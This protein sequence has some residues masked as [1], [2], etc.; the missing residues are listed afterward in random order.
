MKASAARTASVTL[1]TVCMCSAPASRICRLTGAGSPQ[2]VEMIGTRSAKQTASVSA[3]GRAKTRFAANG[4]PISRRTKPM[5]WRA[6]SGP[7]Q[8]NA[9][10]PS[11]PA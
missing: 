4:R 2:K 6:P 10:M 8:V 7:R 3:T 9:S 5:S 1:P 11:P